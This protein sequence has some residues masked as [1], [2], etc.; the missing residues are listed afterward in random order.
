MCLSS[1]GGQSLIAVRTQEK[2]NFREWSKK[3]KLFVPNEIHNKKNYA[4]AHA[5]NT[6]PSICITSIPSFLPSVSQVRDYVC[7][8]ET[9]SHKNSFK[10]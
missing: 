7:K 3:M 1:Y 2:R 6:T 8:Q 4:Q 9:A 10:N 5:K